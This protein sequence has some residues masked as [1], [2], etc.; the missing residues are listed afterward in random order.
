MGNLSQPTHQRSSLLK[1]AQESARQ[2][3]TKTQQPAALTI[4]GSDNSGGAGIETD[5]KT[6]TTLGAYGTA[7]ITCVVAETPRRV[8]SIQGMPA[9]LVRE[10]IELVFESFPVGAAKTGMLYS[11]PI[12]RAVAASLTTVADTVALVVDPVMVASSGDPLLKP[13]AISAL[14]TRLLP[15]AAL[16]TPNLDEAALLW[17][18]PIRSLE[19]L[20]RAGLELSEAFGTAFL[21][22]G[23]HLEG[24]TAVDFLCDS[25]GLEN[26]AGRRGRKAYRAFRARR[27]SGVNTHGTGCTYSAAITAALARGFALGDA[28]A[29]GKKFITRAIR[30]AVQLG[31]ERL[32]NTLPDQPLL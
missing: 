17:G 16:V 28:V 15:K 21:V 12:I 27:I 23:G 10:Q 25:R 32:L 7:A 22:K 6:F 9:R 8:G 14:R 3:G 13:E 19:I 11:A 5:L 30:R 2:P 18:K 20:Q 26:A 4:A 1:A 24:E 29:L 31:D